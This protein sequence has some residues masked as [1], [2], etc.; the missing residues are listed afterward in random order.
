LRVGAATLA[1]NYQRSPGT[2]TLEVNRTGTGACTLDFSPALS[3]RS[4]VTAVELNGRSL[5]FRMNEGSGDQHASMTIPVTQA[6]STV[7]IH[8]KNDFGV[9]LA[10]SLPA[11][12]SASQ[13][14]RVI[15]ETWN[16]GRTQMTLTLAGLPGKTYQ[17]L[18]WKPSQITSVEGGKLQ[19]AHQDQATLSV[20]FPPGSADAYTHQNVVVNF[21][22][23]K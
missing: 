4:S 13:G 9:S 19:A 12:G 21:A 15:S 23:S 1:L 10:N 2:I 14:L 18:V 20:E 5:A 3:L 16:A 8:L 7:R 22:G 17:L 11:L 6:S